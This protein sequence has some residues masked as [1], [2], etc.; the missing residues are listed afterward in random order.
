MLNLKWEKIEKRRVRLARRAGRFIHFF[1]GPQLGRPSPSR[2]QELEFLAAAADHHDANAKVAST[3]GFT[4][5]AARAPPARRPRH[6]PGPL[7]IS[8]SPGT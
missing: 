1:V 8:S 2:L 3:A 5:G 6:G 7:S 4:L